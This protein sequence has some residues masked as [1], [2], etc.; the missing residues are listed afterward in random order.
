VDPSGL[1][2][3][4]GKSENC[5]LFEAKRQDAIANLAKIADKY[6]DKGGVESKEYKRAKAALEAYGEPG[7]KNNVFVTFTRQSEG[8]NTR[9]IFANN[10]KGPLRSITVNINLASLKGDSS[11][12]LVGH[13][14]AHVDY[15]QTIGNN[16]KDK[17]NFEYQGHYVQS[18]LAEAQYP[19]S[20]YHVT[21]KNKKTYD[22][23]NASW[24]GPDKETLRTNAI[25]TWLNVPMNLGGYGPNPPPPPRP[26]TRTIPRRR[27]R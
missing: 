6:K 26:R 8:G 17:R 11:Q 2:V 1:Y 15:F 24:E 23:W 4:K 25:N 19:D 16:T 7:E 27:N 21:D 12:A 3:C 10:G 22:I 9:G 14:G 5:E 20:S 18:L 13:E